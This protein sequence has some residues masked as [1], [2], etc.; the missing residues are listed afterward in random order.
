MNVPYVRP[1]PFFGNTFKM[2][3][4]LEH[5][6]ETFDRFY[7]QFPGEK[8]C[9]FYQMTT[10]MLMVRDPELINNM[11][12]KDFSHFTDRGLDV[13]PE[14]NLFGRSLVFSKG[15]KWRT[16]RQKLSPGFTSG[17]IKGTYDQIKL[18]SQ[19][20]VDCIKEKS[21]Q[22]NQIEVKGITANFATDVI[23]TYAF[24]LKLDT[25]KNDDSD[26]SKYTSKLFEGGTLR[27]IKSS[28]SILF[29]KFAKFLKL[30]LF[31]KDAIDFFRSVFGEVIKY[32][33]ENNII[34]NDL[35]ETLLE[36]RKELVLNNAGENEDKFID[37]DIIG[38]A[39]IMFIS[40]SEPIATV[41]SFC[42]YE[43]ALNK[44]IQK[45]LRAEIISTKEIHGG[46]FTHDFV[47]DLHYTDMVLEETLRKYSINV[48]LFR[49]ATE[50]YKVPG[51]SL[52][53]EKGQKIIIPMHSIHH[54]SK[55]YPNPDT[56]DP[57]R[58]TLEEKSKRRP[59]GS[60]FPFGDGPRHCIGK[61]FAEIDM[62]LVLS[63]VLS[64]FEVA[65]CEKTDVPL[66][67]KP[68]TGFLTAL[69]GVWLSFTQ[70]A[71]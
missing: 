54:D 33:T 1:I 19:D 30:E 9:G 57:E 70:I 14:V 46:K 12:I 55:Y 17:K 31:P 3:T 37:L 10:P 63:E 66:R 32:R 34:R 39:I 20:L 61:R 25:I 71:D 47:M 45:K 7:R 59:S 2:A 60:Y 22:N 52:I 58:F 49:E 40:G 48:V 26:F 62:K 11:L 36:A 38:N 29:P 5:Q 43:L 35:T 69:N 15:Q 64:K 18:C 8:Y 4:T 28:I 67:F 51:D 23:G 13:D 42:L 44:D 41:I 16:L 27:L 56:F 68:N 53:I 6:I 65:T 21:K 24:G 50:K